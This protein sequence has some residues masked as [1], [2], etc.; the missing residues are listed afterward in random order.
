MIALAIVAAV[1][2]LLALVPVGG[3]VS[4]DE[5]GLNIWAAAGA[6]RVHVYPPRPK[7]HGGNRVRRGR[8]SVKK[9]KK[10]KSAPK[11][12]STDEPKKPGGLAAFHPYLELGREMLGRLHHKLR[13]REL[14]AYVWFGGT[15][16]A[17]TAIAYGRAWAAL[18][19][20]TAV[21]ENLFLIEKRD[22]GAKL[23]YTKEK[24]ELQLL[25]D[26]RMR[27]G[28]AAVLAFWAGVRLLKLLRQKR[29]GGAK[30]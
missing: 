15:D 9:E 12:E 1:L 19:T 22:I 25:L 20:L 24:I 7:K 21:L 8:P 17:Q 26:L 11:K 16:A 28:D 2:V 4:Y 5:D 14:R 18:G 10:T 23:D 6:L 3:R 27:I 29:K 30:A 13:V